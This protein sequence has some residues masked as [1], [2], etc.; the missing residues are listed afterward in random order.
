MIRPDPG[1]GSEICML[2]WGRGRRWRL[3]LNIAKPKA[4]RQTPA[5]PAPTAT[6]ALAATERPKSEGGATA[7]P[8]EDA[9]SD[10][11][12]DVVVLGSE[13]VSEAEES[14]LAADVVVYA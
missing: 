13:A 8:V 9:D 1:S 2:P 10:D 3:L 11:D 6:P 7:P 5:A 12:V 4:R 14:S